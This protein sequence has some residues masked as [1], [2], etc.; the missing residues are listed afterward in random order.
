MNYSVP[1]LKLDFTQGQYAEVQRLGNGN[2]Q[3]K[4]I[5]KIHDVV[6]LTFADGETGIYLRV[7]RYS[8]LE[9]IRANMG[10]FFVKEINPASKNELV[11]HYQTVRAAGQLADSELV[12]VASIPVRREIGDGSDIID[13]MSNPPTSMFVL[14][15]SLYFVCESLLISHKI[16]TSP[17]ISVD[18]LFKAT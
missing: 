14:P 11:I 8:F 12:S 5:L 10:G 17:A 3:A 18:M 13:L 15:V 2:S 4:Y 7:T 16:W 9:D 1:R 6:L